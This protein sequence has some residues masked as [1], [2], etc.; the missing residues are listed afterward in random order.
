MRQLLY[1]SLLGPQDD[2]SSALCPIRSH[3]V[4]W[5]SPYNQKNLCTDMEQPDK[6]GKYQ[7]LHAMPVL[8]VHGNGSSPSCLLCPRW[9]TSSMPVRSFYEKQLAILLQTRPQ[10]P[11]SAVLFDTAHSAKFLNTKV[12]K[13]VSSG[14]IQPGTVGIMKHLC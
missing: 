6:T 3:T 10:P 14:W 1:T 11:D 5:R 4:A 13:S 12:T 2:A 7:F 9:V 8:W